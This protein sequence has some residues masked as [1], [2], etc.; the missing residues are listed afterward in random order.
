MR[1]RFPRHWHL[2]SF[3]NDNILK[4]KELKTCLL[5]LDKLSQTLTYSSSKVSIVRMTKFKRGQAK[6]SQIS[7]E[8]SFRAEHFLI[9]KKKAFSDGEFFKE[10]MMIIANTVLKDEK[11]GTDLSSTLTDVQLGTSTTTRRVS[12][13]SGNLAEQL[14]RDLAKC[15]WFSIQCD[16]SVDSSSTAQLFVFIRMVYND[17]SRCENHK[18]QQDI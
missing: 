16:E 14:D 1:S 6:N 7:S 3:E 10:A 15:R 11:N 5:S 17:D 8:A 9:K 2:V 4:I 13:T 18:Q 12:L